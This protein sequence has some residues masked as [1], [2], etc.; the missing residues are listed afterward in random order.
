MQFISGA[1]L[2]CCYRASYRIGRFI[3]ILFLLVPISKHL[4][5]S[6]QILQKVQTHVSYMKTK[7][8]E[9]MLDMDSAQWHSFPP[10]HK[11]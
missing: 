4:V 6:V 1:P 5:V 10:P 2:V 11:K 9:N 8:L 3:L 7:I